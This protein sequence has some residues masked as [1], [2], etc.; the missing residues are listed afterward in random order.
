MSGSL[1]ELRAIAG[2]AREYVQRGSLLTEADTKAALIGPLLEWL[3]WDTRDPDEVR[4]E[5]R[6]RQKEE[7][8][9]YGLFVENQPVLLVEAKRLKDPLTT[10]RGWKQIVANAVSAN[11]R[12]CARSNG[13]RVILF[14]LF[15]PTELEE[16]VVVD[17]DLALVDEPDGLTAAEAAQALEL[18][19]K[20]ALQSGRTESAWREQL[21]LRSCRKAVDAFFSNPPEALIGMIRDQSDDPSLSDE[22]IAAC[23]TE[24][25]TATPPVPA[26]LVSES[27]R[28]RVSIACLL[29]GGVIKAGDTWTLKA[30]G[31]TVEGRITPDGEL[32]VGGV[33]YGSPSQ[34]GQQITGWKSFDGWKLWRYTDA[35]GAA[36]PVGEL[37]GRLTGEPP[38]STPA[39]AGAAK[40][41]AAETAVDQH[42]AGRPQSRA[43]F[44]ALLKCLG[45]NVEQFTVGANSKHITISGSSVFVAIAVRR[46]SLR[47][48]LRLD[49]AEAEGHPRLNVQPKGNFE[50]WPALHVSTG[51]SQA[52]E[53]DAELAGLLKRA[54]VAG[55]AVVRGAGAGSRHRRV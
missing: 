27:R 23:I 45:Q 10:E 53:I 22:L 19:S 44:E 25:L 48:G 4:H 8:V 30:A 31:A 11:F 3:G 9:D 35:D 33:R 46:Q 38:P 36:R 47:I 15:H 20:E 51:L 43:L 6:R 5:W 12:W 49:A 18:L 26:R 13:R 55:G 17:V 29:A 14:D 21:A 16:K 41:P 42:F 32:L 7:P 52:S 1:E 2:R 39:A 50:G 24:R 37:R 54:G 34:A 40:K 28:R